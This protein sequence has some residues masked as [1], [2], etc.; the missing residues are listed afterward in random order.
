MYVCMLRTD[1]QLSDG[2]AVVLTDAFMQFVP[3]YS[4]NFFDSENDQSGHQ[5]R[6]LY[7]GPTINNDGFKTVR[8]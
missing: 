8:R 7:S 2:F 1:S 6:W 4:V 5:Q 3:K